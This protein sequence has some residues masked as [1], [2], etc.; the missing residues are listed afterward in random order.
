MSEQ[1]PKYGNRKTEM[2]GYVFDSGAEA[3][4]Y[5]ELKLLMRAETISRLEIHPEFEIVVN[6]RRICNY[7]ADFQYYDF[8]ARQFVVEDVKGVRTSTYRLKKTP[9]GGH[10]RHRDRGGG[11]IK[12]G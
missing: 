2:D 7:F 4:R 10:L 8:E 12:N 9:G 3:R 1:R 5:E 11:S 6:Q